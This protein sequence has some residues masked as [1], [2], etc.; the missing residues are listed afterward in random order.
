MLILPFCS[1][2]RTRPS[3]FSAPEISNKRTSEQLQKAVHA[4][5]PLS[6]TQ[7]LAQPLMYA[8]SQIVFDAEYKLPGSRA[9]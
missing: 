9:S 1:T 2:R 5:L 6:Y 4:K 7:L 8:K 3:E